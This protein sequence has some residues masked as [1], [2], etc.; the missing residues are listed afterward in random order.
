MAKEYTYN[1]YS[2]TG[3]ADDEETS[4]KK[5][6]YEGMLKS[7]PAYRQD[8]AAALALEKAKSG[9]LDRGAFDYD[10]TGDALYKQYAEQ[11]AKQGKL[12]ADNVQAIA[13]ART[14][15]YGNTYAQTVGQQQYNQYM[16]QLNEVIPEL[17]QMA[18]SRYQDEGNDALNRY[19]LLSDE[20]AKDYD[21]FSD[22]Y[23]RWANETEL[24]RN[25][26]Q[27]AIT[28]AR[29]DEEYGY[30]KAQSEEQT[31]YER[32]QA[33]L[34][35]RLAYLK[36]SGASGTSGE[37][38]ASGEGGAAASAK[39]LSPSELVSITDKLSTYAEN[40][41]ISGI[42]TIGRGLIG[43]YDTEFV[44]DVMS[45]YLTEEEMQKYFGK[46]AEIEGLDI[47][48]IYSE[49]QRGGANRAKDYLLELLNGGITSSNIR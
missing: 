27:D 36:A 49:S 41:N 6:S 44:L 3:Y 32:E 47:A 17:Y 26:Y 29:A 19:K 31:A 15:G 20:E 12:A 25:D 38:G 23:T 39:A 35:N 24:A 13:S 1:G 22:S 28:R 11:Y 10:V 34:A 16:S 43:D 14:G 4:K 45:D 5:S 8:S 48:K 33:A 2:A 18:Y 46:E 9:Y 40:G 42:A 7:K 30:S 21:R 37:S